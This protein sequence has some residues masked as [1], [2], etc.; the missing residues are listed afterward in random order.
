MQIRTLVFLLALFAL[1]HAAHAASFSDAVDSLERQWGDVCLTHKPS[2]TEAR[3]CT[4][5]SQA[6]SK[7]MRDTIGLTADRHAVLRELGLVSIQTCSEQLMKRPELRFAGVP[8]QT[9]IAECAIS[10]YAKTLRDNGG[11]E[12]IVQKYLEFLESKEDPEL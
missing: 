1:P 11:P 12:G 6:A 3:E 2:L 10:R 8:A 9:L 5:A 7:R 4:Q